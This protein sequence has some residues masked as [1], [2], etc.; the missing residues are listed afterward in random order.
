MS[1]AVDIEHLPLQGAVLEV[2]THSDGRT[3]VTFKNLA[4][5]YFVDDAAS[6]LETLL[7]AI[8]RSASSGEELKLTYAL[9]GKKLNGFQS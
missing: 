4:A 6:D 5:I 7:D 8:T 9:N 1:D 2:G 3:R